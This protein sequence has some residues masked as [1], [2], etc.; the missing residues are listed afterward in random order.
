MPNHV[1]TSQR[2]HPTA[3][4]MCSSNRGNLLTTHTPASCAGGRYS[5][6]LDNAVTQGR[7][8]CATRSTSLARYLRDWFVR[9]L[10]LLQQP[11]LRTPRGCSLEVIWGGGPPAYPLAPTFWSVDYVDGPLEFLLGAV[12]LD[13]RIAL[14]RLTP[15]AS[16]IRLV[17]AL[18]KHGKGGRSMQFSIT[19]WASFLNWRGADPMAPNL[20]GPDGGFLIFSVSILGV[21]Y[22]VLFWEG[23]YGH[24][25]SGIHDGWKWADGGARGGV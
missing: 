3:T 19:D 8:Q 10:A 9:R 12:V 4:Y 2:A 17:P 21:Q 13:S 23:V 6:V 20:G 5:L 1:A 18:E 15:G 11:P 16:R 22:I 7:R 25:R 24:A 14:G